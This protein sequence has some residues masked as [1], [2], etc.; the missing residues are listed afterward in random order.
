MEVHPD[1]KV[2]EVKFGMRVKLSFKTAL[3]RQVSEA[4]EIHQAQLNGYQLLNSKSEYNRCSLPRLKMGDHKELLEA[5][6]EERDKEKKTIEKI[7]NMKKRK[8]RCIDN[9]V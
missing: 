5:L 2:K 9:S 1:K 3:E 4:V 8:K 6:I 7:R